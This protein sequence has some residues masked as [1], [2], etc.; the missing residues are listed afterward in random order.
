MKLGEE[1]N[2]LFTYGLGCFWLGFAFGQNCE[3]ERSLNHFQRLI[4][5]NMMANNTPGLAATKSFLAFYCSWLWGKCDLGFKISGEALE[6]AEKS[7]DILSWAFAYLGRGFSYLAKGYLDEAENYLIKSIR[8]LERINSQTWNAFARFAL[9]EIYWEKGK[10][11]DSKEHFGKAIGFWNDNRT[12]PSFA[13][14][15][16]LGIDRSKVMDQERSIDLETVLTHSKNNKQKF[17]EGYTQ[18]WI[19]EIL[20]QFDHQSLLEAESWITTAIEADIRNGTNWSLGKDYFS[21]ADLLIK[22]GDRLKAEEY[23]GKAI[24][25]FN[26]CGA[27]GWVEKAEKDLASLS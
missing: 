13:N 7:G 4:D 10:F 27:D 5:I 21:Y 22:K 12:V 17:L 2:D 26:D 16:Q 18:R 9:G 6:L 20:R 1:T 3:F 25:T 14:L 11:S 8:C 15:A 23:L 19:S 24:E